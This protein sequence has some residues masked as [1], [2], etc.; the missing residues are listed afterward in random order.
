MTSF[1][2]TQKKS[3]IKLSGQ[4]IGLPLKFSSPLIVGDDSLHLGDL[5]AQSL[6][7]RSV[8]IRR[9]QNEKRLLLSALTATQW[10]AGEHLPYADDDLLHSEFWIWNC[11]S[12]AISFKFL[13]ILVNKCRDNLRSGP[14]VLERKHWKSAFVYDAVQCSQSVVSNNDNLESKQLNPKPP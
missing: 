10:T 3:C 1:L 8:L 6:S 5:K 9:Q 4:E 11:R 7:E 2:K 13:R 12:R 14:A